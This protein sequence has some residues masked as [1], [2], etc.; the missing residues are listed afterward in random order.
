MTKNISTAILLNITV[1]SFSCSSA[2]ED[3]PLVYIEKISNSYINLE[4]N[5]Q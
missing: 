4:D 1:Q 5:P 2:S 3:L